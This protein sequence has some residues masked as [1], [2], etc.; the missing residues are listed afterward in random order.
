VVNTSDLFVCNQARARLSRKPRLA[1]VFKGEDEKDYCILGLKK[2]KS[3]EDEVNKTI[4]AA[5]NHQASI[6]YYDTSYWNSE[7]AKKLFV[8]LFGESVS[9][10]L[11]KRFYSLRHSNYLEASWIDVVDTYDKDG[12]YFQDPATVP[13][14]M[15]SLQICSSLQEPTKQV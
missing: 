4:S 3:A 7:E 2:R 5:T 1:E 15:P 8:P 12:L 9:D 13:A 6:D 11:E 14:P 10:C